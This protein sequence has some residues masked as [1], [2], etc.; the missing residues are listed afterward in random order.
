[1][2]LIPA[3]LSHWLHQV[4]V[5]VATWFQFMT[6]TKYLCMLLSIL[7]VGWVTLLRSPR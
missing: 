5:I 4:G 2:N 1:M 3:F 6:P 7:V